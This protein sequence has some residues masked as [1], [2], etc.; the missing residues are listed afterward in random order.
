MPPVMLLKVIF[1]YFVE[2]HLFLLVIVLFHLSHR[3]A[4]VLNEVADDIDLLGS[5]ITI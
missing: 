2:L 4:E 3:M 1:E 5:Q